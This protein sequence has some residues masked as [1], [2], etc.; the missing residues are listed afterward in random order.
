[1][2]GVWND[3]SSTADWMD[4]RFGVF[5]LKK[6]RFLDDSGFLA[7]MADQSW[8]FFVVSLSS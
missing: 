5:E 7:N 3:C 8:L 6:L 2:L 4:F 1:M